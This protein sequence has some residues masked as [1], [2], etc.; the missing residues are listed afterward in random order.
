MTNVKLLGCLELFK[1]L[2]VCPDRERLLRP[3]KSVPPSD[4]DHQQL[5]VPD[6]IVSLCQVQGP[7]RVDHFNTDV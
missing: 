1:V 4:L 2:V 5:L 6:V 7:L 3:P